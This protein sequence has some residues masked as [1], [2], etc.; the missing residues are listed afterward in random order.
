ML[1]F[2]LQTEL[3]AHPPE[4][5]EDT[6]LGS[7][8]AFSEQIFGDYYNGQQDAKERKNTANSANVVSMAGLVIFLSQQ[9]F[10]QVISTLT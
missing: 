9:T 3:T 8:L 7:E 5:P 1:F 10:R 2:H 4:R 6:A